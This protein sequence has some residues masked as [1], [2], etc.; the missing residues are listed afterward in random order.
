MKPQAHVNVRIARKAGAGGVKF[1]RVTRYACYV[2]ALVSS[3]FCKFIGVCTRVQVNV[4]VV[5]H[6][7]WLRSIV[8]HAAWLRSAATKHFAPHVR[9]N[10]CYILV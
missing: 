7:A 1:F 9:L 3:I 4:S 10:C 6:A 5:K 8:K 2:N